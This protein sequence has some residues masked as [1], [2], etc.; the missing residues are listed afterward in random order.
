MR[1]LAMAFAEVT[2]TAALAAYPWIGK[3]DNNSADGASTQAMREQLNQMDINGTVV[4]GEG[5]MDQ[6][7]MLYIGEELGKAAGPALDIAVDPIDGTRLVAKG[8]ENAIAVI[9]AAEAGGLLHAPDMYMKK[10]AVGPAAAGKVDVEAPLLENMKAVARAQGKT[11]GELH[12]MIQERERHQTLIAQVQEAGAHV[13]LFSDVDITGAVATALEGMETDMLVGTGG[14]P[15]GVVA[16]VAMKGLGGD[17]QGQLVP[18]NDGETDRCRQMGLVSPERVL[19]LDDLV[20]SDRCVFAATGVT[21]GK[22]LRG[23]SRN[24][25]DSLLTHTF[26]TCNNDSRY[27]FMDTHHESALLV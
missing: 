27:H 6:A 25:G 22:L 11:L 19:T 10:I 21:K 18:Q 15:E 26:M 12:V 13:Q 8:Q 9:A 4:I 23:V 2:Q 17:F 14:A 3:G 16:A 7:P 1:E 24:N 20:C 5:E